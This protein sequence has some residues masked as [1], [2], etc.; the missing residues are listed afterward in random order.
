M[1]KVEFAYKGNVITISCSEND[2]M[3]EICKKYTTKVSIDINNV[4]FLYSGNKINLQLTFEQAANRIDKERKIMSVL[5]NE[6]NTE[7]K[8]S[9]VIKSLF[10]I[11]PICKQSIKYDI[12]DYKILCSGCKNGHSKKILIKDYEN[13]QKID[14]SN[15]KC[16]L[17]NKNKYYT[18]SNQMFICNECKCQLCPICKSKHN[19]T[20]IVI[21]YDLKDYMCMIHNENYISY[22]N[23]C[24]SD[25]CMKCQKNHKGHE[26]FLYSELMP[27]K[28]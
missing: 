12:V 22:C 10:P 3:E 14:L 6:I 2:K 26:N 5:V 18:Y 8:N 27:D 7:I 17:C 28:D 19:K 9:S 1:A 20:H 25:L 16:N 21:D 13:Y 24:K 15:I 11:C 4:C 23:Y